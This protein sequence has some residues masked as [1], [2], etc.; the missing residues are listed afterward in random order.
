MRERWGGGVE[1]GVRKKMR[2]RKKERERERE[3]EKER[4]RGEKQG[5]NC[6]RSNWVARAK[7]QAWQL[8]TAVLFLC[9]VV[10]LSKAPT[11]LT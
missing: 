9:L 5:G 8:R 1:E 4:E 7:T 11:D 6:C 3:R 2:E 10:C